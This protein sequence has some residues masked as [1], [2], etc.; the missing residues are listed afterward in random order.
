MHLHLQ[1]LKWDYSK[2]THLLKN[3]IQI[4]TTNTLQSFQTQRMYC[5][6]I[7]PSNAVPNTLLL[8]VRRV[9]V[10][11]SQGAPGLAAL[12]LCRDAQVEIESLTVFDGVPR[13]VPCCLSSEAPQ[14]V[15]RRADNDELCEFNEPLC[16]ADIRANSALKLDFFMFQVLWRT[17]RSAP[18][19]A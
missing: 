9:G 4:H 13:A 1:L 6:T 19:R 11:V 12:S 10:R 3:I 18:P 16:C 17:R 2:F 5:K 14:L 8:Y 7:P 15:Y